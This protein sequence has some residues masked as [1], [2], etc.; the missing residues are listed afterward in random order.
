M[1]SYLASISS[2]TK[3]ALFGFVFGWIFIL[4][5]TLMAFLESSFAFSWANIAFLHRTRSLLWIIDSAPVIL[6][7]VASFAGIREDKLQ[8]IFRNQQA[9]IDRQTQDLR[10]EVE[11]RKHA[12]HATRQQK[13]FFET[14]FTNSPLAIV[15]IDQNQDIVAS[16][17]A[18]HKMFGFEEAE[19]QG[20]NLDSLIA[21]G[22]ENDKA[23]AY[24]KQVSGGETVQQITQ[25]NRKDGSLVDV[26]LFGVPVAVDGSAMGA[27]AIYQDISQRIEAENTII[28][29]KEAA[30]E[31]TRA[32]SEFLANMS[33]EIRTPLN[34]IVGMAGLLLD[35]DLS[36]NQKE[37]AE[38][39]RGGSDALLSIINDI[40]DFSKIEAGKMDLEEQSFDLRDCVESSL[41]LLAPIAADKGLELAYQ[42][43]KS[44]PEGIVGDVTRLRQI[45]VNLLGNAIKFT[46]KGEIVVTVQSHILDAGKHEIRFEVR[47]TGIG[48][49]EEGQKRLF[50]SFSQVDSSTTRKYG[51]T[52]LGLTIS[53][54][55]ASMMGG[56]MWVE[57]E[58]GKGTS[59]FFTI[60][61]HKGDATRSSHREQHIRQVKG[62]SVLIVD[63]NATNR[64]ILVDQ[65]AQ[66]GMTSEAVSSGSE[67]LKLLKQENMTFDLAILDMQMP[68]MD[69]FTLAGEIRKLFSEIELPLVLLT[70]MG[71]QK[72]REGDVKFS[73][74]LNKPIKPSY[75]LDTLMDV[76]DKSTERAERVDIKA[77]KLDQQMAEKFPLKMLL[78]ED[79]MVNQ[80]VAFSILER[81]GYR[82]DL[83][84]NGLEAVT[85]V[86]RQVYDLVFMDVQ[87]PEMDG[88]EATKAIRA[89]ISVTEQPR[90]VA[91]TAN[92]LEGHREEYI[93]AGMDDY[94]SK[95]VR[96]EDLVA[97][98]SRC[99]KTKVEQDTCDWHSNLA[100]WSLRHSWHKFI[101]GGNNK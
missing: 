33:H 83:A 18:F 96:L 16:N 94:V 59:F 68:G 22:T 60:L 13:E 71:R 58:V 28:A 15:T 20:N 97:S 66:W 2:K 78:V 37:Y 56:R 91:M 29:A 73:A 24:S 92:A 72:V 39:I 77:M 70:S 43:Y 74:M 90:I 82:A 62:T 79:N 81:L 67:A 69:G 19:L 57:S 88:V 38:T 41:D 17:P 80:K 14:L 55:L 84:A 47:D 101:A 9:E 30:E 11:E 93:S 61:A 65:T 52:G 45:L 1:H 42:F 54:Q 95:P 4:L 23:L 3:Y 49:S 12:E 75:L 85:A 98:I 87:M 44:V 32:K 35:T 63:D 21:K 7:I 25:R 53:Q 46:E 48:I 50:R 10:S 36:N 64:R 99:Y 100:L 27:L 51:G 26:E 34:A 40:L 89:N 31:A 6:G 76:L 86:E 5:A 8:L